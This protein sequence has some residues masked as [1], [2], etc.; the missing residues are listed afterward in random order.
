MNKFRFKLLISCF[1][2]SLTIISLS[3]S[4]FAWYVNNSFANSSISGSV[5]DKINLID[6]NDIMYQFLQYDGTNYSITDQWNRFDSTVTMSKYDVIAGENKREEEILVRL[7]V[8]DSSKPINISANTQYSDYNFQFDSTEQAPYSVLYLSNVIG[9]TPFE[10]DGNN[11]VF[12]SDNI[13][14]F[15]DY[16]SST[17]NQSTTVPL[18]VKDEYAYFLVDFNDDLV[19][20]VY[21]VNIGNSILDNKLSF[22]NDVKYCVTEEFIQ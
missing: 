5:E 6:K 10:F 19:E 20:L 4:L 13:V 1:T 12:S 18:V 21:T 11:V 16:G 7:K 3:V 14:S 15:V 9:F 8:F 2:I 22:V 17:K